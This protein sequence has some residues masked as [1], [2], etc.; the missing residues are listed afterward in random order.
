M[1]TERKPRH[2]DLISADTALKR[3]A[4]R[5]LEIAQ[6]TGTPCWVLRDGEL[7]DIAKLPVRPGNN[8]QRAST[9]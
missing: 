1:T 9:K 6:R 2:P 8:R 3:A 5:A 4:R 7:V